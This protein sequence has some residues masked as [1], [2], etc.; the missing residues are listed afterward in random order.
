MKIK[1]ERT[2]GAPNGWVTV[3]TWRFDAPHNKGTLHLVVAK[4]P[5]WQYSLAVIGHELIESLYC[6][7][8]AITTKECDA[9]DLRCEK[10]FL[11]GA[12]DPHSEPGFDSAA[13]YRIGHVMGSWWERIVIHGTLASW[14]KYDEECNR[15]MGISNSIKE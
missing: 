7:L 12:R 11:L 4:L 5:K 15:V 3:G 10:E 2:D 9:F 14:R 13:P 6:W 1:I 8:F